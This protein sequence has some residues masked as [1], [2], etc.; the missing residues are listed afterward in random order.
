MKLSYVCKITVLE[1][2]LLIVYRCTADIRTYIGEG[3]DN[4]YGVFVPYP[5]WYFLTDGT[6]NTVSFRREFRGYE[7]RDLGV[8]LINTALPP[9]SPHIHAI[10][11]H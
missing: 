5:H 2:R 11:R 6:Y 4:I 8:A 7:E 1:D 9:A 3:V 10:L